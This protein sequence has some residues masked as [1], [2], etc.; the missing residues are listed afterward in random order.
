MAAFSLTIANGLTLSRLVFSPVFVMVFF[1]GEQT[2]WGRITCLLIIALFEITDLLDGYYARK[3]NEVSDVGKLLDP[4]ADSVSRFSVL[5]SL[6]M[7]GYAHLWMIALIFYRDITVANI[8]MA[9][10]KKGIVVAARKS[11]KIK[12]ILQGIGTLL[13]FI[14]LVVE[15]ILEMASVE[16]SFP[17]EKIFFW[18]MMGITLFTVYSAF[19][20]LRG[21]REVFKGLSQ[22]EV[23]GDQ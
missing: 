21:N 17:F 15:K 11:G 22:T 8:R 19:D 2:L 7:A 20:Y 3:R 12:A 6:S 18:I 14:G 1:F 13:I 16:H 23:T 4:Y 9:A 10:L 5:L